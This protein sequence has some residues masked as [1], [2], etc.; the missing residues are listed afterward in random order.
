M[1]IIVK[2]YPRLFGQKRKVKA[3]Y[4][5]DENGKKQG[6]YQ[7]Y[8]R[9]GQE[10]VT[11]WYKDNLKQG[12]YVSKH[13]NGRTA[14]ECF[15]QNDDLEGS[16][17]SFYVTGLPQFSGHFHKN[18]GEGKQTWF[19]PDGSISYYEHQH[20]GK[21]EGES[22]TFS[23]DEVTHTLFSN[24]E[25]KCIT[26]LSSGCSSEI[27]Q[28]F[29]ENRLKSQTQNY[30]DG[31]HNLLE[32]IVFVSD[33]D[34]THTTFFPGSGKV[35]AVWTESGR[36]KEGLLTRY[37]ESGRK[38]EECP[39]AHN[40]IQGKRILFYDNPSNSPKEESEYAK[41]EMDGLSIERDE[42]G[43]IIGKNRYA[44]GKKIVLRH[45]SELRFYKLAEKD[46]RHTLA[47]EMVKLNKELKRESARLLAQN[48][49]SEQSDIPRRTAL[50]LD[51]E[52]CRS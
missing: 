47:E 37:F 32:S 10:N 51:T 3:R 23:R 38:A 9:N 29:H 49:H 1:P 21:R 4:I 43:H 39:Y 33:Q 45:M 7:S 2:Y 18:L 13:P 24:G 52:K 50:K 41:N 14:T 19:R 20:L 34:S 12:K 6:L 22:V 11:C 5:V 31:E 28:D 8:H 44:K 40:L 15:Y 42:D 26:K 46:R 30:Y 16:Y 36:L 17:N 27:I 35:Q 48:Y 25:E